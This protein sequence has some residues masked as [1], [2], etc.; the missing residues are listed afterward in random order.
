MGRKLIVNF[1]EYEFYSFHKAI[2]VLEYEFGYEGLA[3]DVVKNS[4]S[5]EILCEFL[6]DD[7][8]DAELK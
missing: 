7:D 8:I 4:N 5:M 3:W 2:E 1:G 6:N